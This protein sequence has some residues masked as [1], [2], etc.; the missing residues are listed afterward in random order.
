MTSND[1]RKVLKAAAGTA[2]ATI[3]GIP[4]ELAAQAAAARGGILVYGTTQK[5]RHLNSAVQS[6][7]ATMMPAAQIFASPL[8]LDA[9]WNPRPYLAERWDASSDGRSITLHLRKNAKFHDGKPVTSADVEFSIRTVRDNHPF[10]TML[11]AVNGVTTP[12]AHTA[13]IRLAEPHPVLTLAMTTSF[14]PIIPKHVFDDGKE[15]KTHPMNA[16]PVGSGPFRLVEFKPGEHVIMERFADFFLPGE[17]RIDRL[18]IR[19]FKDTASLVLALE[20]GELDFTNVL[21]DPRDLARARRIPST[22]VVEPDGGAIGPICWLAFNTANEKLKDKRVRQAINYAIDKKFMIEQ[23]V[24]GVHARA[25]G[26]IAVGS[27]FYSSKVERYELNLEKAKALL[28][29]AGFKPGANGVRLAL[30][31]DSVPGVADL[32]AMQELLKPQLAKVGIDVTVRLSPDFPT[33][34]RRVA[35]HQFDMT[36]DS[37]WNW[38]DPVIGVHRTWISSNIRKGVIWSNTQSYANPRVDALCA[39]AG[40]TQDSATRKKLYA[41]FQQ[42][43]VDDCPVAFLWEWTGRTVYNKTVVNPPHSPWGMMTPFTQIGAKKA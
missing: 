43:V 3:F 5:P 35:S 20:R 25:T 28:D 21:N 11:S 39:E 37:V 16:R 32:K 41:E 1:R 33:W 24:G 40:K 36:L 18:I 15:I 14:I 13:I 42:I 19:E 9:K 23:I 27:P 38:G 2:G 7:I 26:P 31:V 34:A 10:K 22:T 17:P 12:D 4:L 30:S 29:A 8:T 6:G